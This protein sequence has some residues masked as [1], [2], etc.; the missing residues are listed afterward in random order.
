MK[1]SNQTFHN[2]QHHREIW[3]KYAALLETMKFCKRSKEKYILV[4]T[5]HTFVLLHESDH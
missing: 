4:K 5:K 1:P 3:I 2:K